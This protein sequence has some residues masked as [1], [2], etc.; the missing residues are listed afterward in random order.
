MAK[1]L[2]FDEAARLKIRTGV[3]KLARAVAVT[4]G[5]RGRNV[6]IDK[7]FGKPVVTKDG[8]TV[9]KEIE[10]PDPFENLGAKLVN[11]VAGKTSSAVGDGTTTATILAEA[12][13]TEGL[14]T[15]VAGTSV[16]AL[17]RGIDRAT[18]A[19]VAALKAQSREIQGRDDVRKVALISSR[20]DA[21]AEVV[22]DA[23]EK[24][25]KDGIITIDEGRGLDT[26]VEVVDGF[27]LD[28]GYL[29]PY[30][31]TDAETL[32]CELDEPLI[33]LY[34]KKI[35]S[36]RDVLPVLESVLSLGRPLLI[37]A[38]DVEGEALA[39]LVVNRLR[40][41][42]KVCAVKAPGF[43]ERR[44]AMLEDLAVL[45]G[46]TFISE[47][48]GMKLEG[49]RADALGQ[50]RK[51]TVDKKTTTIVEGGGS[52]EAI[53]KRRAQIEELRRQSTS[54]YDRE[55][56]AERLA[57]LEGG[58][59]QIEA[60]GATEMDMKERKARIDDAVH[61]A[62]AALEEG[63]IPG[64]GVGYVHCLDALDALE[65]AGDEKAGI[66]VV[67]RALCEP[68][69]RIATNAG[70][71]GAVVAEDAKTRGGAAGLDARTAE[72]VDM[73]EAG[74]IDP[75]KVARTALEQAAGIAGLMLTTETL[76]TDL[77]DDEK[78][79]AGAVR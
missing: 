16:T 14:K 37:I 52:A 63:V 20:E 27:Q 66:A 31:M 7:S 70:L 36:L 72:W 38:E 26:R 79:L 4:L 9:S 30:F 64:G 43:G 53:A 18:G 54:D 49:I 13:F 62:R 25:G 45:T 24:V 32:D 46:G 3:Q 68:I 77:K 58:V 6:I 35:S 55:K 11:E 48:T 29:S 5:P 60:G 17:K 10:L 76:I 21:I 1:Q 8:V 50:A 51:V 23:F 71:D 69:R 78:E 33:L 39:A 73:W 34:E 47:D 44:K 22:A 61:T 56:L 41:T 57:K 19:A 42:L 40:G 59:A 74:I 65:A 15:V 28:K 12:I 67:R 2:M 75:T